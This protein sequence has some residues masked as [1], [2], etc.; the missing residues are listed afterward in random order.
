MAENSQGVHGILMRK[1]PHLSE[2]GEN[3]AKKNRTLLDC[4]GPV[5]M[6][7]NG[8]F[9]WHLLNHNFPI[10]LFCCVT[11]VF[12][13][14]KASKTGRLWVI[15]EINTLTKSYIWS[16]KMTYHFRADARQLPANTSSTLNLTGIYLKSVKCT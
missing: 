9:K 8:A 3:N 15:S 2:Y 1:Q 11:K 16:E 7:C 14:Q 5:V 4:L 10:L 6:C 13:R 12:Y